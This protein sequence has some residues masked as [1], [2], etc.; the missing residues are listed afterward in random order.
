MAAFQAAA[1]KFRFKFSRRDVF[2][3]YNW[4]KHGP[5]PYSLQL[6]YYREMQKKWPK[7]KKYTA[8]VCTSPIG[9]LGVIEFLK[10]LGLMP[11]KDI[12]VVGYGNSSE[13]G[14]DVSTVD[15]LWIETG[16]TAVKTIMHAIAHPGEPVRHVKIPTRFRVGTTTGAVRHDPDPD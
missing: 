13:V 6:Y 1:E 14:A 7:L 2:Q 11:G 4:R 9:V 5:P 10:D 3:F 15:K 16:K 8:L 12:S